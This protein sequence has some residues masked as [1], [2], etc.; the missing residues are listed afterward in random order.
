[1]LIARPGQYSTKQEGSSNIVIAKQK[2]KSEQSAFVPV[3]H[4]NVMGIVS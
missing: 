1:M 2:K 4:R 3:K